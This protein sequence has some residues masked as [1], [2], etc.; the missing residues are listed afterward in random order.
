MLLRLAIN[1]CAALAVGL[2]QMFDAEGYEVVVAA[3]SRT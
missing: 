2:R 3:I 1:G